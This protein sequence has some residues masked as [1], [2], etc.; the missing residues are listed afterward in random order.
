[1]PE[2]FIAEKA[3][4][5]P[6]A[7]S[8]PSSAADT[9]VTVVW[10][11]NVRPGPAAE[12]DARR[13]VSLL[14]SRR[15]QA[16]RGPQGEPLAALALD[17]LLRLGYPHALMLSPEALTDAKASRD[18]TNSWPRLLFVFAAGAGAGWLVNLLVYLSR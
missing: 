7:S 5:E 4:A 1:M 17:A 3:A 14:E 12:S 13:L 11:Q 15:L 9:E 16:L 8:V 2:K 18:T 6:E 10:L